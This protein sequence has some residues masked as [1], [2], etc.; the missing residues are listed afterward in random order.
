MFNSPKVIQWKR[1]LDRAYSQAV[2]SGNI[3]IVSRAG[4][5]KVNSEGTSGTERNV[6]CYQE[7]FQR[8][9]SSVL[10]GPR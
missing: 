9:A 4:D 7:A 6:R 5:C 10:A 1:E 2:A 8:K 3:L